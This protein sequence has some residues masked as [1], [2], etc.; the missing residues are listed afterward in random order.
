MEISHFAFDG[1]PYTDP[2]YGFGMEAPIEPS[3]NRFSAFSGYGGLTESE[4]EELIM[5]C[6]DVKTKDQMQKIMDSYAPGADVQE[7]FEEER[8]LFL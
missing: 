3:M 6:K 1:M 2:P 5:R 4:K 8:D 7:M